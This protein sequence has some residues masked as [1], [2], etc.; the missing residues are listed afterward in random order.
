MFPP[1]KVSSLYCSMGFGKRER[2]VVISCARHRHQ[3]P[4]QNT[5]HQ[6]RR[7]KRDI[8]EERRGTHAQRVRVGDVEVRRAPAERGD[9]REHVPAA[10]RKVGVLAVP[11]VERAR[12]HARHAR[13]EVLDG[14][15]RVQQRAVPGV[16]SV[17]R[18]SA[19][20][21]LA[22][23]GAHRTERTAARKRVHARRAK[24][25][26]PATSS[27]PSIVSRRR[28]RTRTAQTR[29]HAVDIAGQGPRRCVCRTD[30]AR[31]RGAGRGPDQPCAFA[32][33]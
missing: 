2:C 30:A 24:S 14:P 21:G 33:F 1:K 10:A 16:V 26:A 32:P 7:R 11:H 19:H 4:H 13:E 17:S 25:R 20:D 15:E 6:Q 27:V 8:N 23:E 5:H 3:L 31:H 29:T 28:T 22:E 9:V 18:V 12:R